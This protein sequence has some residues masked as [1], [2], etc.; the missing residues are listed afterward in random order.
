[1]PDARRALHPPDARPARGDARPAALFIDVTRLVGRKLKGRLPT[2]VD[3]VA[4]EYVR[5]FGRPAPQPPQGLPRRP[6]AAAWLRLGRWAF[7]L[8]PSASRR[9]F[10]WL[11]ADPAAPSFPALGVALAA[12]RAALIGPVPRGPALLINAFHSGLEHGH[13]ARSWRQ[14]GPR[15]LCVVHD[16]IP[17]THP[18]TCRAGEAERHARRMRHALQWSAALVANSAATRDD[19]AAWA[20]RQGL[21]MPPL[22]VA[23]LAP[24]FAPRPDSATPAPPTDPQPHFVMLGTI[25]PRK[26]HRTILEAWRRLA[27]RHGPQAPRLV[28]VGQRGWECDDVMATLEQLRA[29]SGL[30]DV[31]PRC[32]DDELRGLLGTARALLFPSLTEGFGMP[33]VEAL[34]LGTPVIASDLPVFRELAGERP[35]YRPALDTAA[36]VE[37]VDAYARPLSAPRQA[38]LER[39]AGYHPPSWGEHFVRVERLVDQALGLAPA[40]SDAAAAA[41]TPA[42]ATAETAAT[43]G[44]AATASAAPAAGP[45]P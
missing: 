39:L 18:Q 41:T 6:A 10:D 27:E 4:L 7:A 37:A 22:V 35:D 9:L 21:A 24:G 16:L 11:L 42:V 45:P 17:I 44:S 29:H 2:G 19:L 34:A 38:Q 28:L 23:W 32:S 31:R 36:W 5:H 14:R 26:N 15:L 13:Y 1:M 25:E 43:T 30:V 33:L 20:A 3:R 12:L 40:A 8:P